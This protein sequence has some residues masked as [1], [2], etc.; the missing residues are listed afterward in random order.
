MRKEYSFMGFC[1]SFFV[2]SACC[3]LHH[4][5]SMTIYLGNSLAPLSFLRINDF[6]TIIP[7]LF[8]SNYFDLCIS[9]IRFFF[10]QSY[11]QQQDIS[12]DKAPRFGVRRVCII[13]RPSFKCRQI[14][15][16]MV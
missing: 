13:S 7:H 8:L 3:S 4:T 1:L 10:M 15:P 14:S 6:T 12:Y 9:N 2:F 5:M 11:F 16:S